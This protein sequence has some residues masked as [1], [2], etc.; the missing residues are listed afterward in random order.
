MEIEFI[1]NLETHISPIVA[2]YHLNKRAGSYCMA[3][4]LDHDKKEMSHINITNIHLMISEVV[5]FIP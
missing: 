1:L 2:L 4:L 3:V 5:F